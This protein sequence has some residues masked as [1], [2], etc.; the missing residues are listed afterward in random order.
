[1]KY[2]DNYEGKHCCDTMKA[3]LED[4]R[5]MIDYD[6]E[7]NEYFIPLNYPYHKMLQT[8][9]YCPWCGKKLDVRT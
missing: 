1:M 8:L 6:V 3:N 2:N 7:D 4:H 9:F 5:V